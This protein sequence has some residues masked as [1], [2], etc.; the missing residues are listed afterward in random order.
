MVKLTTSTRGALGLARCLLLLHA[1][2]GRR[3]LL[4]ARCEATGRRLTMVSVEQVVA[5]YAGR[6]R[7]ERCVGECATHAAGGRMWPAG[8]DSSAGPRTPPP[9]RDTPATVILMPRV[10]WRHFAASIPALARFGHVATGIVYLVVGVVALK[11]AVDVRT[12]PLAS[13]TALR[14]TFTGTIGAVTLTALAVGLAA[15]C[16]WQMVRTF[17]T[18][19]RKHTVAA[20][21]D[22]VGWFVSGL[23]H[24]SLGIT[25]ARAAI[26]LRTPSAERTTR[27]FTRA[28]MELPSGSWVIGATGSVL[29]IV[30]LV[31]AVRGWTA[32]LH[33]HRLRL[34]ELHGVMRIVVR[35]AWA[36]SLVVRGIVLALAGMLLIAAAVHLRPD[37]ARGLGGTLEIIQARGYGT[38]ALAL[39]GLGFLCNGILEIVRARYRQIPTLPL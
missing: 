38:P 18:I 16:V 30:G 11:A 33:D 36:F 15:D 39:V 5:R 27:S 7:V 2:P 9:A 1:R 6:C 26:G 3:L 24:L 14:N 25:A 37:D 10:L 17:S 23:L 32:D 35:V 29:V 12:V 13:D 22:R 20:I 8:N 4:C 31:L 34:R 28:V 19:E 21:A